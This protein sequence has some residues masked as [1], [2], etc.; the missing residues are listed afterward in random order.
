MN[1]LK[2]CVLLIS[3]ASAWMCLGACAHG[4]SSKDD[5]EVP[6]HIRERQTL[7]H[8]SYAEPRPDNAPIDPGFRGF[9]E[10]EI[11]TDIEHEQGSHQ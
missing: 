9:S 7:R 11:S 2:H 10:A 3:C 4:P 6:E 8:D 1:R 5:Y